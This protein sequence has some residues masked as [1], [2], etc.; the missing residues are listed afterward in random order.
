MKQVLHI[1]QRILV[2]HRHGSW[3]GSFKIFLQIKQ[4]TSSGVKSAQPRLSIF[5]VAVTFFLF[6]AI[7][8]S[9]K[10]RKIKILE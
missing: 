3:I 10:V 6:G 8:E 2:E 7:F 9:L 1:V 4:I 5:L